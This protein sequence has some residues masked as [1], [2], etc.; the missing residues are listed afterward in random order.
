MSVP[1]PRNKTEA[2]KW[3]L[4]NKGTAFFPIRDWPYVHQRHGMSSNLMNLERLNYWT[5]LVGNGL[6]P[7][8]A[9]RMVAVNARDDV[10]SQLQSIERKFAN[11]TLLNSSYFDIYDK[12]IYNLIN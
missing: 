9:S 10:G 1:R 3:N 4:L 8:T 11:K 5:F 2:K 7:Q 6:P 12:E